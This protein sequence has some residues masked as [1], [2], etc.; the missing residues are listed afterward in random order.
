[1][2]SSIARKLLSTSGTTRIVLVFVV[3]LVLGRS[4]RPFEDEFEDEDEP[5]NPEAACGSWA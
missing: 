3:V 1:V 2:L 4:E 5:S